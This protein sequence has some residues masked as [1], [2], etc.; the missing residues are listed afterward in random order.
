MLLIELWNYFFVKQRIFS[1]AMIPP[2]INMYLMEIDFTYF[3]GT[4]MVSQIICILSFF[5]IWRIGKKLN[6][7][8]TAGKTNDTL[9]SEK[10]WIISY[11]LLHKLWNVIIFHPRVTQFHSVWWYDAVVSEST[12]TLLK[13]LCNGINTVRI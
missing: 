5:G 6:S 13:Q 1:G 7:R 12:T 2:L 8:Y 9:L 11:F 4:V 3:I 10:H